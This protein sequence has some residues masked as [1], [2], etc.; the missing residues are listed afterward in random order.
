MEEEFVMRMIGAVLTFVGILCLSMA[1]YWWGEGTV[2][3]L[4][5][6]MALPIVGLA[7]LI[8]GRPPGEW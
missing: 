7:M 8:T 6:G 1:I 3:T 4:L 2:L 5:A